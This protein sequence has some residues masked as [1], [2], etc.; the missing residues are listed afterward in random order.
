[1]F[2]G[3]I[4]IFPFSMIVSSISWGSDAGM[5]LRGFVDEPG[6]VKPIAT[7]MGTLTN[8]GW[9]TSARVGESGGWNF[10]LDVSIAYIGTAD[11]TYTFYYNNH[12]DSLR[13]EGYNCIVSDETNDG[14]VENAPTIF[15]PNTS[16]VYYGFFATGDASTSVY[17]E[18][19]D[20]VR[21][22]D[23]DVRKWT[24]I[25]FPFFHFAYSHSHFKG[26]LRGLFVPS[27][28]VL[29]GFYLIGIGLQYDYTR[30]LPPAFNAKG[31]NASVAFDINKWHLSYKPD[32]DVTGELLLDG[33]TTY[34]SLVT[35]W[36][37][38]KAEL[39]LDFGYETSSFDAGGTMTDN[40]PDAGQDPLIEPN[41]SV[42]G[43]NGFRVGLS[44][45]MHLGSWQPVVGQSLGA[46]W[47][48]T[49]NLIQFGKEGEK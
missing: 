24:T 20:R 23:S 37:F 47:G 14:V 29:G 10:G 6:Y 44:V 2:S 30:F 16:E 35:G 15:G 8:S 12:C 49:V 28:D 45:A 46:Q 36:R 21:S 18:R 43:R 22:G 3:L 17:P 27:I 11:H 42:D 32:G 1:R 39:I 40:E 26:G 38:G 13:D 48:T 4:K 7:L 41:V 25:P 31:F 34:T 9:V 19:I 5:T 33:L